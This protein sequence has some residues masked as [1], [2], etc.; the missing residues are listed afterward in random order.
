VDDA[1]R[2]ARRTQDGPARVRRVAPAVARAQ[3]LRT[4]SSARQ[5]HGETAL[6][7]DVTYAAGRFRLDS[8]APGA[9]YQMVM[10]YDEDKFIPI[11]EYDAA[12][13]VLRLGLKTV[14][15]VTL[16]DHDEDDKPSLD[17]A[18][19]PGIPLALS[20]E[21]GAAEATAEF[22]GLS[23][24]SLRYKTGASHTDLRFSRPNPIACDSMDLE[25]GAA[26][27]TATGLAN[28]NCRHL[29]IGG[30]VGALTLDFSGD[31]RGPTD[32][33]AHLALGELKLEVPR[34]LGVAITLD[35]FL[36]S[37]EQNGFTKRG[38][39]YYSGNYA[40]TRAHLNVRV[41]SAFGG[42]QVVWVDAAP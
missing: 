21:L 16:A 6:T 33:D 17:L 12:T 4:L 25:A 8:A 20:V 35:R 22:G 13:G 3:P 14:G 5:L 41:Q 32:V 37:F 1:A 42:I 10:R 11:R 38:D 15:H 31:W 27:L 28:A 23:L 36:A 34:N 39:V 7:V 30:G 2:H 26:Q 19:A 24:R 40:A 18:L 9:L 29:T